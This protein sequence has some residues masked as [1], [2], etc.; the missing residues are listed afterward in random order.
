MVLV[1]GGVPKLDSLYRRRTDQAWVIEC[2]RHFHKKFMVKAQKAVIVRRGEVGVEKQYTWHCKECQAMIGYQGYDTPASMHSG[3]FIKS[4]MYST[5]PEEL[6][7]GPGTK[8]K[9]PS[10]L[11]EDREKRKHFYIRAILPSG[12]PTVVQDAQ[13]SEL[14]TKI[15]EIKQGAQPI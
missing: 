10:Q 4:S 3:N 1:L 12:L 11:A 5:H 6:V 13:E 2:D 15:R 14:L 8:G 9:D 7:G